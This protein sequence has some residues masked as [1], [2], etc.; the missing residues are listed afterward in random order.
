MHFGYARADGDG[1]S[2]EQPARFIVGVAEH[3]EEKDSERNVGESAV[4]IG[5]HVSSIT[6]LVQD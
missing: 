3:D 5:K 4:A 2:E 6:Q 1:W